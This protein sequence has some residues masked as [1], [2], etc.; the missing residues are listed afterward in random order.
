MTTSDSILQ[1]LSADQATTEAIADTLRLPPI[2]IAA[3]LCDL[4]TAGLVASAPLGNPDTGRKLA[5]WRITE[6]GKDR[7]ES[8]KA[9]A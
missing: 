7:A 4:E 5:T 8:I 9:S 1:L 2:V 6:S 3:F